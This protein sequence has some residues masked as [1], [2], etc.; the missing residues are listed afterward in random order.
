MLLF[1]TIKSINLITFLT[2]VSDLNV[3]IKR[4]I[5]SPQQNKYNL[6][7]K[8]NYTGNNFKSSVVNILNLANL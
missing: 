7:H 8:I 5:K 3:D 2:I 4:H 6:N 1:K